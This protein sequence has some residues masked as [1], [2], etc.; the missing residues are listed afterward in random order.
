MTKREAYMAMKQKN[1]I[2]NKMLKA[3]AYGK[4]KRSIDDII[5]LILKNLQML[6]L[7]KVRKFVYN[8]STV[9]TKLPILP[10]ASV[11]KFEDGSTTLNGNNDASLNKSD[12][13]IIELKTSAGAILGLPPGME[14][15]KSP[16]L[17]CKEETEKEYTLVLDLDETLIHFVDMGPDSY[18]L[19][20]PGA[21]Q[22]LEEMYKYYEIVVFT[23]G[24]KDYADWVLDQ[25]DT[26]NHIKFRLYRHHVR[27][28]GV[29]L[30]KDLDKIGRNLKKTL[31][32]DNVA[33]NFSKQP[34][35][36]IFIKTWYNDME[37]TCLTDLIPLLKRL[38]ED[39]VD[40]VGKALRK[41]RDQI[42]RLITAGVESPDIQLIKN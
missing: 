42:I 18:F 29:Y 25:L 13:P 36:G 35:H 37:D 28:N 4:P 24:M 19:I 11:R 5:S 8:S 22:F 33:E 15:P 30:V 40:D 10:G 7:A 23:A 27:Q 6:D 41:Y 32:I 39:K 38:V 12:P 17:P 16:F 9:K 2:L 14:L 20:R 3:A 26:E 34:D 1:D 21:Q 31:I